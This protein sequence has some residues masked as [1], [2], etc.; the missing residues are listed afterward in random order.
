MRYSRHLTK[1]DN[2]P[3][4]SDTAQVADLTDL[5]FGNIAYPRDEALHWEKAFYNRFL[6]AQSMTNEEITQVY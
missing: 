3:S 1:P 6:E 2:L 4:E 5:L